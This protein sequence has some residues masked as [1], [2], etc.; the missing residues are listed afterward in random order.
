M[1]PARL[2]V[3]RIARAHGLRGEVV[4]ELTTNR[5]ERVSTGSVLFAGERPLTVERATPHQGRW[6]VAFEGLLDRPAADSLRGQELTADPIDDPEALWVHEL[7]GCRLVD[8]DGTDRGRIVAIESNPASD[9]AV[10]EGGGLV[11]LRFVNFHQPGTP[12]E[13]GSPGEPGSAGEP[14]TAG[15]PGI[16]RAELPLG[17]LD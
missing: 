4:V 8:Q 7:V 12:V 9:L 13:S 16:V 6:L 5:L 10:L 15:R 17:L 3:G 1:G 14:G 11:P 2:E